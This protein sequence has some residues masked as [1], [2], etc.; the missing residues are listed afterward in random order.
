MA[1]CEFCG[2]SIR[3][4]FECEGSDGRTFGVGRNCVNKVEAP[5]SSLRAQVEKAAKEQEQ[6]ALDARVQRLRDQL[7]TDPD[8][9]RDA[10][11]PMRRGEKL[12]D[13]VEFVFANGGACALK[14]ACTL[15]EQHA[16]NLAVRPKRR[17]R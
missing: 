5:G 16:G 14:R 3:Y 15:A 9:L 11:H 8:Y 4:K 6:A 13:Y 12:R 17:P 1:K 10:P 2:R 7:A